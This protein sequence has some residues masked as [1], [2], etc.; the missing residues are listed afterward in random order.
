MA[1]KKKN[2]DQDRTIKTLVLVTAVLNL[3]R[4]ILDTIETLLE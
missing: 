2:G 4:A 1:R 3:I